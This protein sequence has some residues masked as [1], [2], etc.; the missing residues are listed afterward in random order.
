MDVDHE[1]KLDLSLKEIRVPFMN[2]VW[3]IKQ[4]RQPTTYAARWTRMNSPFVQY[5]IDSIALRNS[6][7]QLDDLS[8]YNRLM[9]LVVSI[10]SQRNEK[11]PRLFLR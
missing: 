5:N 10:L 1:L 6:N 7:L 2:A 3:T 11:D 8:R 4:R 9:E